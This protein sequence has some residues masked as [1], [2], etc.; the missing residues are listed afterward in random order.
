MPPHILLLAGS[1]EARRVA[2]GL[3]ARGIS[4]DAWLSEA[5]RGAA[6]LPQT[7]HLRR[8]DTSAQMQA[9]VSDGGYTALID[10][11][12]VFD[13]SVTVQALAA[14][15][16]LDLPYLRIERPAWDTAQ[17]ARWCSAPDTVAA[18]TLIKPDARVFC[19]TGWDSLPD[20]ADFRGEVLMLRQTRRHARTAPFAF[21]DLVFGDPPFDIEQELALFTDLRV[22][23]LMCRNLGGQ[24]SRPKLDAAAALD[25]DVILIDRPCVPTGIPMVAEI[26][27]ALAWV[28]AL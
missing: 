21:V 9:Q 22:S 27:A 8:F 6:P 14:A 19:A 26:D 7:P 10:A 28:T 11:S 20:F 2:E 12:H 4:Y 24:A 15:R 16:A 5:P 25:L 17:N 23:T 3:A 1:F 18:N 13:R